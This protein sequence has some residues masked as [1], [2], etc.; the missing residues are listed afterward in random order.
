METIYGE[1]GRGIRSR[2]LEMGMTLEDLAE[3]SS[4]HPAFI[5]LIERGHKK[6]SLATLSSIASALDLDVA[7]LFKNAR[8]AQKGTFA[9]RIDLLLRVRTG[10]EQQLLFS[11]LR[12]IA[13]KLKELKSTGG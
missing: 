9:R 2:R 8:P 12:H 10:A 3:G 1:V 6:A 11:T 7:Q 4:R 13:G 5:G